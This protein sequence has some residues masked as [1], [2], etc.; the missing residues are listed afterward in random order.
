MERSS[1]FARARSRALSVRVTS[2]SI[3]KIARS[4][5]SF[6]ASASTRSMPARASLASASTFCTMGLPSMRAA[7]SLTVCSPLATPVVFAVY[8][9]S[10]SAA[11][12]PIASP[13]FQ[14]L[15]QPC[16]RVEEVEDRGAHAEP[17][18]GQ[19][20]LVMQV[21]AARH[22][23][24]DDETPVRDE[25]EPGAVDI[26]RWAGRLLE[27]SILRFDG[28]AVVLV[29][30]DV[31]LV[32]VDDLADAV[33]SRPLVRGERAYAFGAGAPA[34]PLTRG[35]Q[36]TVARASAYSLPRVQ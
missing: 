14:D 7:D 28:N 32:V 31:V 21:D 8:S 36:S 20:R 34:S 24:G 13:P 1:T 11:R 10:S 18:P 16:R 29:D 6:L 30:G 26:R 17:R 4:D 27:L 35:A 12:S 23:L 9:T 33:E 2:A 22:Q 19:H 15:T 3:C 5:T 25:G